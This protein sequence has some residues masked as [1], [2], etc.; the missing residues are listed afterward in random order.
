VGLDDFIDRGII[1]DTSCFLIL[2]DI[3]VFRIAKLKSQKRRPVAISLSRDCLP[4]IPLLYYFVETP[5][6]SSQL[7]SIPELITRV[8]II[9]DLRTPASRPASARLA[10]NPLLL[11]HGIGTVTRSP[12]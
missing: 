2:K 12:V 4:Y 9:S 6:E 10:H 5:T 7:D 11:P 1:S 3:E 8:P